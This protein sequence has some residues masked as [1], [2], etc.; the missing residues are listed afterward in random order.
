MN[1]YLSLGTVISFTTII[2]IHDSGVYLLFGYDISANLMLLEL[3]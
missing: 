1:D 3:F 2:V